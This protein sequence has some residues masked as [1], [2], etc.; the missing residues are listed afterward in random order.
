RRLRAVLDIPVFHDDQH[1]TAVVV[2][3]GILNAMRLLRRRLEDAKIVICGAGAAGTAI[4]RLLLRRGAR[5]MIR[6][7]VHGI[8]YGGRESGMNPVLAELAAQADGGRRG[9]P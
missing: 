1:G 5:G 3:A 6:T 4:A 2:L 8:V 9:G 7:D